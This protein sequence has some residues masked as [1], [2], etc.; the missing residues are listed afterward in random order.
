MCI[1]DRYY[2]LARAQ[3]ALGVADA[4]ANYERFLELRGDA[5]PPD[6]RAADARK[7]LDT[8]TATARRPVPLPSAA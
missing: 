5:D 1:R 4:P 2:F 7:R 6:P 8:E 3:E